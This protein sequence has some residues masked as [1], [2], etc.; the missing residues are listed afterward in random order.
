MINRNTLL[1]L[2]IVAFTLVAPSR[3][4]SFRCGSNVIH[5]GMSTVA[6]RKRCGEPQHIE[7][8]QEHITGRRGNATGYDVG[9]AL[10]ELWTYD[11]GRGRFPARL[12]IEEGVAVRVEL[13]TK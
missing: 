5:E 11:L 4:D 13:L 7:R 6:V 9:V 2:A 12:T 3:A 10:R 8:V 1:P